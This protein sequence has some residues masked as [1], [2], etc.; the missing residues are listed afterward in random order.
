[1]RGFTLIEIMVAVSIFAIVM[2]IGVGALLSLVEINKRAQAVNAVM[3]NLNA[4]VEGMSRAIR[5]GTTYHCETSAAVPSPAVLAGAADC[6]GGGGLL[7]AFESADG[8]AAVDTDQ[9]VYRLNG[10]QLERSL[11]AGVAGSWVA[12]T[13]PEVNIS[14]FQFLVTG[15]DTFASGDSVQPRVVISIRGTA[16]VSGSE[17]EFRIQ[18]SVVQRLIDI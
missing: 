3:N 18:S 13:A 7:L 14:D 2:M 12:L 17:T 16:A 9:V 6:P 4:A 5:V 8:D 11:E 1:M 10:T 15:T